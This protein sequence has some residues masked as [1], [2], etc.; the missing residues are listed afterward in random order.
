[1]QG[2]LIGCLEIAVGM[3]AYIVKAWDSVKHI[4]HLDKRS[5]DVETSN[6]TKSGCC[7]SQRGNI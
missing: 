5:L 4:I 3:T 7:T 6:F 2:K 1:M